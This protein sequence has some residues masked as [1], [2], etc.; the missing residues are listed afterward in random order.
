MSNPF[1]ELDGTLTAAEAEGLANMPMPSL[2]ERFHTNEDAAFYTGTLAGGIRGQGSNTTERDQAVD[3]YDAMPQ[4]ETPLDGLAALGGQVWGSVQ[5]PETLL[6]LGAGARALEFM[7]VKSAGWMAR[8]FAGA[9]D[10]AITNAGTDA[11]VQQMEIAGG[12]RQAFDFTQLAAST[13]VGAL[14]GG[15][16]GSLLGKAAPG[17]VGTPTKLEQAAPDANS[18]PAAAVKPEPEK[19]AVDAPQVQQAAMQAPA[20]GD[21][22]DAKARQVRQLPL[23]EPAKAMAAEGEPAVTSGKPDELAALSQGP[24]VGQLRRDEQGVAAQAADLKE[25][26]QFTRLKDVAEELQ[27]ALDATAVRMGRIS[28]A[29][30][31]G[32]YKVNSGVIRLKSPDDFD[33]LT[34]ELGHHIEAHI[35][36]PVQSLMKAHEAELRPMAYAGADPRVQLEE[37]FAE[38]MRLHVTNPNYARQKAPQFDAAL[39]D[40][41]AKDHADMGAALDKAAKAWRQWLEQPSTTAVASTIVSSR[42]PKWFPKLKKQLG[43]YGLGGTIAERI[44]GFYTGAMDDLHPLNRAVRGLAAVYHENTGKLLDLK[45][46]DDA[47]KLAR[48]ARGGYNAGHMDIMHGV[49]PYRGQQPGSSS[50]RDALVMAMDGANALSKWDDV[51]LQQFGSYLWSRRALG[52]WER[53]Q[54]GLIP[55]PPDKLTQG[56]HVQNIKDL[57]AAFPAFKEA[58]PMVHDFA[59]ALWTKKRDAGLITHEQWQDGLNIKDYVPGLRAFDQLGDAARGGGN[60]GDMKGSLVKQFKG[61]KRDVLNPVESLITDAYETANAIARNDVVKALDRLARKAGPGG[62]AIAELIPSHQMRAITVDMMEAL[63]KT[64]KDNG[65]ADADYLAMRDM[66]EGALGDDVRTTLFRPAVINEKGEAIAFFRDGGELRA[67]RLA[68]GEFGKQMHAAL[69]MMTR[70]ESNVF[71]SLL[72]KPAAVLRTGITASPEF[73]LANFIR[74]QTVAAI[75]YGKPLQRVAGAVAGM[76]DELFGRDAARAYNQAGGIMGGANVAALGDA[77]GRRDMQA[78]RRKGWAAE[79]L[80]SLHGL[81]EATAVSETGMRLGLFKSFLREAQGRGLSEVEAMLEAAFRA[82]DHL[83]FDRRGSVMTGLARLIPFL[84][85]SLQG[86]DKGWRQMMQPLFSTAVTAAEQKAKADAVKAHARLMALAVASMGLH[87]LMSQN[88]EYNDISPQTRATHWVVKWGDKWLF[89]PKPFE[90]GAVINLGEAAWDAMKRHDPRWSE[91]YLQGLYEVALPPNVMEGNP[92]IASSYEL[93]TGVDLRSGQSVVPDGMEGME[94]WLQFSAKTSEFSRMLGKAANV[95]PAIVDHLITAHAGSLGRNALALYDYALSD[96]PL[97]GW[98]DVAF[99]RRF[100]K[101]GSRGASSTR[102]FWGLVG[103]R[104]GQLEGARKSWEKMA[105]G[106]DEGAAADFLA[107]QDATTKTWIAAQAAKPEVRRLHPLAR[108]RNAVT[109]I[110]D[111]R[112][113]MMQSGIETAEGRIEIS[114]ASRGVADDILEDLAMTEARNALVMM[115]V[116]GWQGREVMETAGYYRELQSVSPEL[117]R[118]LADRFATAK[119]VPLDTMEKLWPEAEKRL[120]RDGSDMQQTDLV[121]RIKAAGFEMHGAAIKRKPRHTVP[122]EAKSLP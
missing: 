22:L 65:I 76:G 36:G 38:Y 105:E 119:V 66:L 10:A 107:A 85:A 103:A 111:L 84:N 116:P 90:L 51:R 17:E 12:D 77:R 48:L 2:A 113:D 44:G 80:T 52:E 78:L 61:S 100:I 45:V 73:L 26:P 108:A 53:F 122:G 49:V 106:G 82:R 46:A 56:D 62:G 57:E 72:A 8:F 64:A 40:F 31:I 88:D 98:D 79:R 50:L 37:G 9:F 93:A 91:N 67:L 24:H 34:H 21:V 109:A 110:N 97:P 16:V 30:A 70:G 95:S 92:L 60:A 54:Q 74:D 41:L 75:F 20:L 114:R 115:Q 81:L 5:T 112:R 25:A 94:P 7:G 13:A 71:V 19:A 68:D 47:Y 101:D 4:W 86:I 63:E 117:A 15:G 27:K 3:A 69:T 6:P 104:N 120:L 42:E 14:I 121:A 83:D 89:V 58:A 43:R 32:I 55:N 18:P 1:D 29:K 39:R 35:G 33:T 11:G 102:A 96:K 118:A 99:T 23:R 87:A 59:T 28:K